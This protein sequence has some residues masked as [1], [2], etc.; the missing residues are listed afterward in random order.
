V[1]I[2]RDSVY[3]E[4]GDSVHLQA[5]AQDARGEAI[6]E[7]PIDWGSID[8]GVVAVTPNGITSRAVAIGA[9]TGGVVA[10]ANSLA[11][12]AVVTVLAPLSATTL[13]VHT[14][15]ARSLGDQ[16]VIG[17]SSLSANGPRFGRY[18][19]VSRTTIVSAWFDE[20]AHVVR[21]TAQVPGE[22]YVVVTELRGTADSVLIVVRQRP[23]QLTISPSPVSGF[24]DRSVRLAAAAYDARNNAISGLLFQWRSIDTAIAGVD[25]SGLV[26]FRAVGTTAIITTLAAGL[27]D[28]TPVTVL[29]KPKLT[30]SNWVFGH[31]HDSL[32]VGAHQWTDTLYLDPF[33]AVSPWVHLRVVDTSIAT[34]QDSVLYVNA[35][36]LF[37]VHGR[38][39]GRTLLI[40]E[41]PL[42]LPDT[43]LVH[44]S[45]ARLAIS[46]PV[47]PAPLAI[48]GTDNVRFGVSVM[49]SSG[50]PHSM[51]DTLVVTFHSSDSTVIDLFENRDPY[52]NP[53]GMQGGAIFIAHALDTGRVFI[54]ASAPDYMP[55][56]M[57]WRVLAGPA[58]RF[59]RGRSTILGAGQTTG[60]SLQ[61]ASIGPEAPGDT[62]VVTLTQAHPASVVVPSQLTL[63]GFTGTGLIADY[64]VN[65]MLP[66][67]DTVIAT[68]SGHDPDTAIITVTTPKILI[69]DTVLG[70]T[71][72]V[73]ASVFVGDSLD[74]PHAPTAELL[75]LGSSSDTSVVRDSS[76]RIPAGWLALWA[77]AFPTVDTGVATVTVRDS[78]GLYPPKIVTYKAALDSSL[79][80][81]AYDGYEFGPAATRQRFEDSRF[82]LFLPGLP[83]P[84]RVVYLTTTVP[85][86]LQVP[87]SIITGGG[88]SYFQA[89]GGDLPGTTRIVVTS[90]GFRADTSGP[91]EVGQGHLSL[92]APDTVFVGGT[93]YVATVDALSPNGNIRFVMDENLQARL[94]PL[95]PGVVPQP[96]ALIVPAGQAVSPQATLTFTAPGALRLAA[97]DESA[98]P[99][100][101]LSDT[102]TIQARLPWLRMNTL[103][104]D[105]RLIVGAGQRLLVNVFRPNNVVT[106]PAA[107]SVVRLGSRTS[108]ASG[109]VLPAGAASAPFAID[110]RAVG[111]DTLIP[112]A[113][114]YEGDSVK[115]TVTEGRLQV[116]NWPKFLR[117]GDSTVIA[118]RTLDSVMIPHPVVAQTTFAIKADGLTFSDGARTINSISISADSGT[119]ARFYVKATTVG[120]G[121]VWFVNLDYLPYT[122]QTPVLSRPTS[123]SGQ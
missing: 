81:A 58:L 95:D 30:L 9:G 54:R 70:T 76:T 65:A 8:A 12:T 23:V 72:G 27:A 33:N 3:L 123:H 114:G 51:A 68:A 71:L 59:L 120:T 38:H 40:A 17:V 83:P 77:L 87:D 20:V 97:V 48:R 92:H 111:V 84:A 55:D 108:F 24:L 39:T 99:S 98:V 60:T 50:T 93:G 26:S 110:G 64:G 31:S 67:T 85:S 35:G 21:I 18:T 41:A 117:I 74:V 96:A 82:I 28:T 75:L 80:V 122:F 115:V 107:V 86:V 5:E 25:S 19:A 52:A 109:V 119:S 56:S 13:A 94:V 116:S 69:S 57:A 121:S 32:E 100:P 47:D 22:T 106:N 43:I 53:P 16:L 91:I 36:G 90:R 112:T 10:S 113:P 45:P 11:D 63:T 4:I 62:V 104:L 61:L 37:A 46:D 2:S 6:L 29:P 102:V 79:G 1:L 49:D 88:S 7:A 105:N 15:T 78:A 73:Y 66:G 101:F 34:V 44:V 89:A 14:D 118:L 103:L 42:L